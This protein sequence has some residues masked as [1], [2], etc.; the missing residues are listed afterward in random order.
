MKRKTYCFEMMPEELSCLKGL[1]HLYSMDERF[2]KKNKMAAKHFVDRVCV[3]DDDAAYRKE[4]R[5]KNR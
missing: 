5:R 4:V 2:N 1:I 3:M